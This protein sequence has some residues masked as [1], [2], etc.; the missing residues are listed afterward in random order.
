MLRRFISKNILT[1][2]FDI[3]SS[4]A[5]CQ[6]CR[7]ITMTC[8]PPPSEESQTTACGWR[9]ADEDEYLL[10]IE[11]ESEGIDYG[12][13]FAINI[14]RWFELPVRCTLRGHPNPAM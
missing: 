10:E 14:D 8:T 5:T 1:P 7:R 6:R 12:H 2:A 11:G 13:R 4:I 3:R 9:G